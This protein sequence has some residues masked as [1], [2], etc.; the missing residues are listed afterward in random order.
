MTSGC[1]SRLSKLAPIHTLISRPETFDDIGADA[2]AGIRET[3]VLSPLVDHVADGDND[4]SDA[5]RPPRTEE[6]VASASANELTGL[7]AK[8]YIG[9][10]PYRSR[11]WT[12]SANATDS[13]FGRNV[14]FLV[15]LEGTKP[16]CGIEA[17]LGSGTGAMGLGKILQPYRPDRAAP[18]E[19][20]PQEAL[21]R[22]LDQLVRFVSAQ[23]FVGRISAIGVDNYCLSLEITPRSRVTPKLFSSELQR[24]SISIRPLTLATCLFLTPEQGKGCV[25]IDFSPVSFSA[26]TSFFVIALEMQ[27]GPGVCASASFVVNAALEGA[28]PDRRERTLVELLNNKADLLRFLLLLLEGTGWQGLGGGLDVITNSEEHSNGALRFDQWHALLE[29]LVRALGDDPACLDN[30]NGVIHDL[31]K[32][33]AGRRMIPEGLPSIWDPIWS[34]RQSLRKP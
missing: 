29:P 20:T 16:R 18:R 8:V 28:P 12:G 5:A 19:A 34:A 23:V 30:I 3:L 14:E 2:L 21:E 31:E 22:D 17:T 13:A 4:G 24:A 27:Q 25:G 1:I 11:V 7:H 32:T 10:K 9:E 6:E 33:E 15:E 26:H